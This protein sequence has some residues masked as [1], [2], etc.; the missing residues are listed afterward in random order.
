M[1]MA[2]MAMAQTPTL[3][4]SQSVQMIQ[5]EFSHDQLAEEDSCSC[6]ADTTKIWMATAP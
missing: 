4:P 1:Q 5:W 2:Q 6:Y 3:P